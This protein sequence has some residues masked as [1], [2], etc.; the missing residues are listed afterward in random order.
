MHEN[1]KLVRSSCLVLRIM[2]SG[3]VKYHISRTVWNIYEYDIAKI[4]KKICRRDGA[5]AERIAKCEPTLHDVELI[6]RRASF[7]SLSLKFQILHSIC[8]LVM[9][10]RYFQVIRYYSYYSNKND[11]LKDC[12][13]LSIFSVFVLVSSKAIH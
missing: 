2:L 6:I 11:V 5:F 13:I 4:I 7:K 3:K 9:T 8:T 12:N 1:G 10:F